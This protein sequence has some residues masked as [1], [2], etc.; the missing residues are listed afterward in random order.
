MLP[1]IAQCALI[2]AMA[3]ELATMT[4][5]LLLLT[6]NVITPTLDP[7]AVSQSAIT[8]L[9]TLALLTLSVVGVARPKHAFLEMELELTT[10]TLAPHG[11][12]TDAIALRLALME[13]L[14]SVASVIVL[15]VPLVM[16]APLRRL[17]MDSSTTS[18]LLCPRLMFVTFAEEMELFALVVMESPTVTPTL[19]I[20]ECAKELMIAGMIFCVPLKI[21]TPALLKI[22]VHGVLLLLPADTKEP[23]TM[24]PRFAL[25]PPALAPRTSWTKFLL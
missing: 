11:N 23:S 22:F 16:I 4:T 17:V 9:V 1:T 6:V 3:T 15:L 14:A 8:L 20:A 25:M 18:L 19:I 5:K 13:E 10:T 2:T 7:L 21:V 12:T 24:I